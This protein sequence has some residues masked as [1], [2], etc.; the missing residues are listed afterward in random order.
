MAVISWLPPSYC[1]SDHKGLSSCIMVGLFS[2]IVFSGV[3]WSLFASGTKIW[4]LVGCG[5]LV[6]CNVARN[7]VNDKIFSNTYLER[8]QWTR[9]PTFATEAQQWMARQKSI[10]DDKK[11]LRS[12]S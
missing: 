9:F 11:V 3:S 5:I 1:D 10:C 8:R 7:D 12:F 6:L 2:L 4:L